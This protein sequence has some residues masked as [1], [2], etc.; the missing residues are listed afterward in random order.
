MSLGGADTQ[1]TARRLSRPPPRGAPWPSPRG[2]TAHRSP[3]PPA[4][5]TRRRPACPRSAPGAAK[6]PRP[7]RYTFGG[8]A[9]EDGGTGL[10]ATGHPLEGGR[11]GTTARPPLPSPRTP[12]LRP[13]GH[14]SADPVPPQGREDAPLPPE[15][16]AVPAEGTQQS[17]YATCPRA[18]TC[19]LQQGPR[20]ASEPAPAHKGAT[21]TTPGDNTRTRTV[22]VWGSCPP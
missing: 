6:Q 22:A 14:R 21:R 15:G 20:Q 5:L 13:A 4:R 2:G 12:P 7:N 11:W 3:G 9:G 10:G 8:C 16:A 17:S 1:T 18:P 19:L